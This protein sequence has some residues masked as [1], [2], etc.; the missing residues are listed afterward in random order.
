MIELPEKPAEFGLF[1]MEFLDASAGESIEYSELLLA[2]S[3]VKYEGCMAGRTQTARLPYQLSSMLRPPIGRSHH[4]V[5]LALVW[6]RRKPTSE[7]QSLAF[8]SLTEGNVNV[9]QFDSYASESGRVCLVP[10]DIARAL[11]MSN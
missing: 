11:T 2:Q 1:R 3:L 7:R 10:G 4:D 6:L 5:W 9:P 8:T